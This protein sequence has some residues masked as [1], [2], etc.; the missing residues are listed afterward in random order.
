MAL[1][2]VHYFGMGSGESLQDC[3]QGHRVTGSVLGKVGSLYLQGEKGSQWKP[4]VKPGTSC[5]S[6][7][8]IRVTDDHD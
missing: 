2:I 6:T 5:E 7:A 3:K 8:L 4:G 1:N